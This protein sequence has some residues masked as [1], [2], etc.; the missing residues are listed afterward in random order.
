ME[1]NMQR[2]HVVITGTG[3]SGTS[4]LVELLTHLG[5]YTGFTVD[6]LEK[7]KSKLSRAGLEHDI[8]ETGA[9]YIIKS[10][11]F[12]DYVNDILSRDDIVIEHVFIPMRDLKAAAESRRVVTEQAVERMSF[13]K[14]FQF[15]LFPDHIDGGLTTSEQQQEEKLLRQVYELILALSHTT[16]PITLMRY[17]QIASDPL[18]LFQKLRPILAEITFSEFE[19]AFRKVVQKDLVHSYTETDK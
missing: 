1:L 11:W 4:L 19:P 18:Y 3:R 6:S 17:P 7:C 8:R 5:L 2:R 9:P 10:P 14:R 13:L 16:V 15:R 12:C